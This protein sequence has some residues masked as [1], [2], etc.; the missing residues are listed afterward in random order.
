MKVVQDMK[1]SIMSQKIMATPSKRLGM[2]LSSKW[3]KNYH[4][5]YRKDESA[6]L[7]K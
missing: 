2:E 4:M 6:K 5:K 1:E 7:Y 3:H